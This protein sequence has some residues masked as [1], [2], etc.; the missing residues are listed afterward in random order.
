MKLLKWT[1]GTPRLASRHRV[2]D[3]FETP[4]RR[5]DG[6]ERTM[7]VIACPDWANVVAVT[8]DDQVVLVRQFRPGPCLETL[9]TP[10][11]L[12]DPGE[13]PIDAAAREL[14]E[15][16]GYVARSIEP[17]GAAFANP[18]LQDNRIHFFLA[19]GATLAHEQRFDEGGEECEVVLVPRADLERLLENGV[20]SH[21]LCWAALA[22]AS[23]RLSQRLGDRA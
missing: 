20:F 12:I 8:D 2:F 10:G 19:R 1:R 13:A 14:V 5:E 16:T 23:L 11:G 9:E 6:L 17:L 21:A 15:E 4:F 22:R 3:L 18:A 7:S